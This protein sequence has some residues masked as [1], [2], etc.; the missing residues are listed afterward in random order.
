MMLLI[1]SICLV[2]LF[3]LP[4]ILNVV[5]WLVLFIEAIIILNTVGRR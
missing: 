2:A 3:L 4:I 1:C 5:L